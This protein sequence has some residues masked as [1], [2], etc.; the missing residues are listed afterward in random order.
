MI[1]V[2]VL[3]P[4]YN[5]EIFIAKA[6]DSF[7]AQQVC[8][9]VELLIGDD[10]S[11]DNTPIVAKAYAEKYP[12]KIHFFQYTE[13]KGLMLN[14]KYL[15]GQAKGK[16]IAILESDDEWIDPLKLQKQ[17]EKIENSNNCGLVFSN[18]VIM[19]YNSNETGRSKTPR[20]K[21]DYSG[22]LK[23]NMVAAV[24]V[25]FSREMFDLYCN[26]DDYILLNFKTFDYPVWLSI[27]A[28][29]N[30]IYL[31]DYTAGYR[32]LA[33]SISN[34]SNYQKVLAFNQSVDIIVQYVVDRYGRGRLAIQ[35]LENT[36]IFR[37]LILALQF[38]KFFQ[39]MK[40]AWK[41]HVVDIR[42]FII[43]FFPWIWI[44]KNRKVVRTR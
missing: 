41:L 1:R 36:K 20:N 39:V 13:N 9:D 31:D 19:D 26:I 24:T 35:E 3:M 18:W 7:L 6:I 29:S 30:V 17:V 25:L 11:S 5:H 38:G 33:T 4:T 21:V 28:H 42:T 15:L 12:D 10:F 22:L 8:F 2:S 37:Y 44:C 43:K 16:Y 23:E 14:Y 32:H 34:N 27:S 40:I